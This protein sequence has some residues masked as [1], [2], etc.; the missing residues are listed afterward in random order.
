MNIKIDHSQ[1][2]VHYLECFRFKVNEIEY[3]ILL[4]KTDI[5]SYQYEVWK[6]NGNNLVFVDTVSISLDTFRKYYF[7]DERS[8]NYKIMN[9]IIIPEIVKWELSH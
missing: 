4:N 8:T 3:N 6:K 1:V 9:E 7:A 2:C 5:D